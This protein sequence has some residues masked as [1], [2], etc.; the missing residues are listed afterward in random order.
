MS[1]FVKVCGITDQFSARVAERAGAD[2][3]GFVF[4]ESARRV[5]PESAARISSTLAATTLKVAVF[6]RP[7]Q[8]EV[9][10]VLSI[11]QPDIV[12][13]DAGASLILPSGVG[14]LP[15]VRDNGAPL[16]SAAWRP[17][18]MVLYEGAVSGVGVRAD[19][20][21]ASGLAEDVRLVLAGGLNPENVGEAI[22]TVRPF[23]VDVSSGVEASRGIKDPDLI[24]AFVAAARTSAELLEVP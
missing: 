7:S 15:V 19:W 3:I 18:S 4:A 2:A 12:Q 23:G 16:D 11:F 8:R 10:Q 6:L 14:L 13:A 9:D 1:L 24:S 20:D 17:D 5:S 21:L 22:R